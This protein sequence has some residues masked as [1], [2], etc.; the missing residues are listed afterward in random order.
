MKKIFSIITSLSILLVLTGC[1][2]VENNSESSNLLSNPFENISSDNFTSERPSESADSEET[3]DN[4]LDEWDR[5]NK[6]LQDLAHGGYIIN[7]N[8]N[9]PLVY[10]GQPVKVNIIITTGKENFVDYSVGVLALINDMP[11]EV[12][13]D[14]EKYSYMALY[15]GLEPNKEYTQELYLKPAVLPEDRDDPRVYFADCANPDYKPTERCMAYWGVHWFSGY[16]GNLELKI[17]KEIENPAVY[18]PEINFR[19]EL[20]TTPEKGS[21]EIVLKNNDKTSGYCLNE[22]GTLTGTYKLYNSEASK[23]RIVFFVN[24]CPVT[25]NNGKS[26]CEIDFKEGYKYTFDFKLDENPEHMDLMYA[27]DFYLSPD[28]PHN[29]IPCLNSNRP[30]II[31]R[32]DFVDEHYLKYKDF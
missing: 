21:P 12:S 30:Y 28:S 20:V 6:N 31:V 32:H 22:N 1:T 11:Q 10:D 25:F 26:F 27:L 4:T 23:H 15:T 18:K 29:D 2:K 19:E 16:R 3:P 9:E 5:V 7:Y 14:G 17:N 8:E 13:V 24:D